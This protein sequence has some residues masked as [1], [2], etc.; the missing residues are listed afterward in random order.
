VHHFLGSSSCNCNN[1]GYTPN[2]AIDVTSNLSKA[3]VTRDGSGSA[4]WAI[5]CTA[6]NKIIVRFEGLQKFE[7][8]VRKTLNLRG[9]NLD[10]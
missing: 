9:R 6:C 2:T 7:A 8:S 5:S 1:I 4:T 10:C 3:H